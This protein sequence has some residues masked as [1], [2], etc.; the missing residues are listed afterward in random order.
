MLEIKCPDCG[1]KM[2]GYTDNQINHMLAQHKLV[3]KFGK[4]KIV[5]KMEDDLNANK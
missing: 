5:E 1:K 3:H 2:E 4:E